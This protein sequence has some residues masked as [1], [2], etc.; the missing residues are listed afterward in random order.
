MSASKLPKRLKIQAAS[1]GRRKAHV[2]PPVPKS[3]DESRHSASGGG[4]ASVPTAGH[5]H[6]D[7]GRGG[8]TTYTVVFFSLH[9]EY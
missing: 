9:R 2:W 4:S 1:P 7:P 6:S 3:E 5:T 8:Q